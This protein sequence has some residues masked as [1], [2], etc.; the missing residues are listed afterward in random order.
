MCYQ[1]FALYIGMILV[2]LLYKYRYHA[3]EKPIL[4]TTSVYKLY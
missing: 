3:L 4:A 1:E 2:I